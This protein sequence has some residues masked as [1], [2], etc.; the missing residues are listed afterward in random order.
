MQAP[1]AMQYQNSTIGKSI[2]I[3]GEITASEPP[4]INGHVD[5]SIS[6]PE[7]R[8][9]IGKEGKVRADISAR[10]VVIMGE[11]CGNL[12]GGHRVEIRRDGSLT[13]DVTADRICIEEGAVLKGVI[14]IRKPSEKDKAESNPALEREQ[15]AST[16]ESDYDRET[17]A[18]LAVAEPA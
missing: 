12:E 11:V 10:E 1:S 4:Y 9:T 6:A 17:W 8:V 13:G 2:V 7:Q 18:S 15:A 16:P 5:G 14:D 3:K